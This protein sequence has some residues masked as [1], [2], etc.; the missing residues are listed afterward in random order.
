MRSVTS[1]TVG[2]HQTFRQGFSSEFLFQAMHHHSTIVKGSAWVFEQK[3]RGGSY[4]N[5]ASGD[6]QRQIFNARSSVVLNTFLF[7]HRS[8]LAWAA[9]EDSRRFS[10]APTG[11]STFPGYA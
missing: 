10:C 4:T 8:R 2:D 11:T 5:Y 7:P 9:G 3:G 6:E 1:W